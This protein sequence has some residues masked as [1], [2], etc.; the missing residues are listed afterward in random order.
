MSALSGLNV[1]LRGL[2][3]QQAG[4]DVTGHNI[5]N[6]DT[7][8]YTRQR[9]DLTN[10]L[11]QTLPIA[12]DDGRTQVGQG[13]DV[14]QL[15]R[16][17]DLFLDLQSRAAQ[18]DLGKQQTAAGALARA[19][20]LLQE[21]GDTGVSAL[22]E[23]FWSSW[24]TLAR[25]PESSAAKAA[26]L[27]A[28]KDLAG[29]ISALSTGLTQLQSG[30]AAELTQL[31]GT[32]GPVQTSLQ[33]VARLNAAITSATQNGR[34]PNDLLDRRDVLLDQ[35]STYGQVT[36]T[37]MPDGAIG[38]AMDGQAIVAGPTFTWPASYVA[39][40]GKL[41]QL[42]TLAGAGSPLAAYRADLDAVATTLVGAVNGLQPT[43]FFTGTDAASFAVAGTAAPV[44]SA[45]AAGANDLATQLAALRAGAGDSAYAQLVGRMGADAASAERLHHNAKAVA[46]GA[47][48]R[49]NSVTGVSLDEEMTN[50]IRF[51]RGYQ[52][53]SRVMNTMDEALDTLINRTG[54]VGL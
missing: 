54:R 24:Q 35:L 27:G 53:A 1:A 33:E 30:Y 38:V 25:T 15:S 36:T 11:P 28:G 14:L 22:M 42:Q 20:Q 29:A 9:V 44:A 12:D 34:T 3:A 10:A 7:T 32:S 17:R 39:N 40:A 5:A 51:Q 21:P 49:R 19:E 41:G 46:A 4:L 2:Q 43:A 23:Q 26:V 31:T 13:V 48:Q 52:A 6:V 50:L 47:D 45:G 16:S 37:A 8:G 18:M